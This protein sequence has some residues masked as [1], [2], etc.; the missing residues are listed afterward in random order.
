MLYFDPVVQTFI[1]NL[2]MKTVEVHFDFQ[3]TT[4]HITPN[5]II[6]FDFEQL[7]IGGAM[8]GRRGIFTA[9]VDGTYHF[10]FSGAKDSSITDLNIEMHL[11][12]F[13]PMG[14]S[15]ASNLNYILGVSA[16][17]TSLKLRAGDTI[18]LY[19]S[20]SG[21]LYDTAEGHFTHFEGW[22]QEEELVF[23]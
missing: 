14:M 18:N 22:L 9:P 7:N 6:T 12:G 20:G 17:H 2:D 1:G 16:I 13:I 3:R 21:V 4:S 11:N 19:N 10:S 15:H 5:A 8:D 23:A